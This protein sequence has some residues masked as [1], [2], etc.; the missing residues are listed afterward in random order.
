MSHDQQRVMFYSAAVFNW[1]AC[2]LFT[3]WLGIAPHMGFSPEMSNA[4]FNQIAV[5]AIV[6]FG[7]G[8]WMVAGNPPAHRR[9]I[10]LGLIGKIG[11]IAILFGHYLLVGDVNFNLAGLALGDVVYAA[12]FFRVLK[13]T[14]A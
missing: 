7:Y 1:L 2:V 13:T 14:P 5:F 6:V 10:M 4:P 8:Y 3:P 9:I 12:L 11:V